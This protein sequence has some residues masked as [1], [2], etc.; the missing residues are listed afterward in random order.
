MW[1]FFFP[2]LFHWFFFFILFIVLLLFCWWYRILCE[3]N[4]GKT[5]N[6][7][8][9]PARKSNRLVIQL[10]FSGIVSV[11]R[12]FISFGGIFFS[13]FFFV[14]LCRKGMNECASV[15]YDVIF[16]YDYFYYLSIS[17]QNYSLFLFVCLFL[18]LAVRKKKKKKSRNK[19]KYCSGKVLII[20]YICL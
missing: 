6:N 5:D 16:F 19:R 4:S 8:R 10:V 9:Q 1:I 2:F 7:Y 11:T 20:L 15:L 12:C 3:C 17:I 18:F 14:D 13:F